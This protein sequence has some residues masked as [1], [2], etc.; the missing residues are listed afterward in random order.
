MDTLINAGINGIVDGENLPTQ[1]EALAMAFQTQITSKVTA[2]VISFSIKQAGELLGVSP[3][4][5][6]YLA[7]AGTAISSSFIKNSFLSQFDLS[8]FVKDAFNST[9]V[10][11]DVDLLE[12]INPAFSALKSAG[13]MGA[14]ENILDAG[15]V[16]EGAFSILSKIVPSAFKTTGDLVTGFFGG[17]KTF[18]ELVTDSGPLAAMNSALNSLFTRQTI[19]TV[20]AQGGVE[21]LPVETIFLNGK[22]AQKITLNDNAALY[23][24][25]NGDLISV[26]ENG[27]T[28]T[29]PFAWTPEDGLK[30]RSGT[31]SGSMETGYN[32]WAEIDDGSAR[33]IEIQNADGEEIVTI[34]PETTGKTIDLSTMSVQTVPEFNFTVLNAIIS[35]ANIYIAKINQ[36]FVESITQKVAAISAGS[37]FGESN[38]F[39][40]TLANGICNTEI[41]PNTPPQYIKNLEQDMVNRGNGDISISDIIPVI[42][43]KGMTESS[44]F[45][46]VLDVIKWVAESQG[47]Y[48]D[49]L[50]EKARADLVAYFVAHPSEWNRPIVAMGY[51]GGLMPLVEA[52]SSSVYNVKTLVGLGAATA[53]IKKDLIP[54]LCDLTNYVSNR[55]A[56][57][58][59]FV[60]EKLNIGQQLINQFVE[61]VRTY[62]ST[63]TVISNSAKEIIKEILNVTGLDEMTFPFLAQSK[64]DLI[65]NVWGTKDMLY[66]VGIA[67]QRTNLCGKNTYNIEIVG[68]THFDYMRRDALDAKNPPDTWN[69]TVASFVA[70]LIIA[71][72]D[73]YNLDKFLTKKISEGLLYMDYA[74]GVYVVR[75]PGCDIC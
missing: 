43:Y 28:C 40:Y 25:E 15:G 52:M 1:I 56:D 50:T 19:E 7:S 48:K 16:F 34:D 58:V 26:E 5:S 65:V 51:S 53:Y 35:F 57:A 21:E 55:K 45:N 49:S 31:V 29:G 32:I 44:D 20:A 42:L 6:S 74:R 69:N 27:V 70:D 10:S 62:D 72:E 41:D 47:V 24:D 39:L 37:L 71:S 75:L 68:A 3:A 14:I 66:E 13:L 60:L 54:I 9:I 61:Y 64:T 67:G 11:V 63:S 17:A 4:L 18:I 36:D 22:V 59:R 8:N 38:K 2:E 23:M 33:H 73:S 46:T 12:N 30:L